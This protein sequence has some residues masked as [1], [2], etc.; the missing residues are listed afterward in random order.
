[1]AYTLAKPAH[2][3]IVE[4]KL[5]AWHGQAWLRQDVGGKNILDAV[6]WAGASNGG[7]EAVLATGPDQAAWWLAR[8]CPVGY[9]CHHALH[10]PTPHR[11]PALP[12][13]AM[14]VQQA[15]LECVGGRPG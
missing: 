1:M 6:I 12:V 2:E 15:P 11:S 4:G 10:A 5:S 14:A 13:A 8:A 9:R 7:M 3:K